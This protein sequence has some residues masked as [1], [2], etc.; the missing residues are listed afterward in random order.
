[1]TFRSLASRL[2]LYLALLVAGYFLVQNIY[3]HLDNM[4]QSTVRATYFK[5]GPRRAL[6][7]LSPPKGSQPSTRVVKGFLVPPNA[8][9]GQSTQ[10]FSIGSW[11]VESCPPQGVTIN[12]TADELGVP[13][14]TVQDNPIQIIGVG[15]ARELGLYYDQGWELADELKTDREIGL[16]YAHDLGFTGPLHWSVEGKAGYHE[17]TLPTGD[18]LRGAK[19]TVTGKVGW[20]F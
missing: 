14:A 5:K 7:P 3:L 16:Y 17:V 20:R 11:K 18:R 9:E 6:E 15:R 8:K 19:V 10:E 12:V 1:M 13:H 2:P 4:A